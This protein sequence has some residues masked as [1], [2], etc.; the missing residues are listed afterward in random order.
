MR[1]AV[2]KKSLSEQIYDQLLDDILNG[3][4]KPGDR[5]TNRDLQDR[6]QVSSTPVRDAI[7]RFSSEGFLKNVT[8]A[9]AQIIEFEPDFAKES[10]DYLAIISCD[11]MSLCVSMGD[12]DEVLKGLRKYQKQMEVH[13]ENPIDYAEADFHYHKVFFDHCCNQFFKESFKNT[14]L[15]HR[16]LFTYAVRT[17]R[18]RR[19]C[20]AQHKSITRAYAAGEYE[21]AREEL[22]SHFDYGL[23]LANAY[24]QEGATA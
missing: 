14:N 4:L 8:N 24:Y 6:F 10:N 16:L 1:T 5:L 23:A 11:A 3:V 9:G 7:N 19:L 20:I 13:I 15:L 21:K 12:H 18:E 17:V 2:L 22:M